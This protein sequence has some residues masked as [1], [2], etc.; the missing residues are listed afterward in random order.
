M[1][2]SIRRVTPDRLQIREGGGVIS[3]VGLPFFA[4]GLFLFATVLRIVPVGNASSLPGY[5]WP[6]M[7]LMALLFTAV[8]G[9]LV[10]GRSWTTLDIGRRS[11]TKQWGL[12]VPLRQRTFPI[13]GYSCVRLGFVEGD[14][15]SADRFPVELKANTGANLLVCHFTTYGESRACAAAVAQHLRLDLEDASSDHPIRLSDNHADRSFQDALWRERKPREAASRPRD[16]RSDVSTEA[17]TTRIVI[18]R[19]R[20]H[21][22]T[23]ALGLI[24]LVIPAIVLPQLNRFFRQTETPDAIGWIFLSFV[25]CFFGVL[26]AMSVVNAFLRS[27]RGATIVSVSPQ[28]IRLQERGAWRTRTIATHDT[29]D[30]LDLDYS[31]R[32]SAIASARHA[33]EQQVVTSP[34]LAAAPLG[35]RTERIIMT[36]SRFTRGRGLTLKTRQGLTRFGEGLEDDEVRYL[37]A[38]LLRG[39]RG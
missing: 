29:G 38:V 1:A 30:I 37:Y 34:R 22:L 36:L 21:P 28:G 8:G 16:A 5:A 10:F 2:S 24:P 4:A 39:L 9:T 11:V 12:L 3:V 35:P 6:L 23:L 32:E 7:A 26:P 19:P 17:D 25:T 27:R 15:D 18:P 14:S 33:A 13:D 20:A 31:T